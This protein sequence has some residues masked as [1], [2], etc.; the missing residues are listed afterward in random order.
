MSRALSHALNRRQSAGFNAWA[1]EAALRL[2]F[3]QL[4]RK[5]VGFFVLKNLALGFG[6]WRAGWESAVG[7]GRGASSRP[8]SK[9]VVVL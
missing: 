7:K 5:G 3:M 8:R 1:E 2:E 6:G 9:R 4:L